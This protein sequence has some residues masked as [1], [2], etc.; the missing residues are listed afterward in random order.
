M[1]FEYDFIGIYSKLSSYQYASIGLNNGN[2][3]IYTS[4]GFNNLNVSF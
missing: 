2:W 4:R 1:Y 3:R